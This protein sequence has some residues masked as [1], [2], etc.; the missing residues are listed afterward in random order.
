MLV[1]LDAPLWSLS[2]SCHFSVVDATPRRDGDG[3][4]IDGVDRGG[5]LEV[6]SRGTVERCPSP[7]A[8]VVRACIFHCVWGW[9][10]APRI[11]GAY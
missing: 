6:G 2:L 4:T 11:H 3:T 1:P 5:I 10:E 7:V 9:S 8:L